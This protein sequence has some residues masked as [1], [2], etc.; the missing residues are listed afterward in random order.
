MPEDACL[1]TVKMYQQQLHLL[2]NWKTSSRDTLSEGSVCSLQSLCQSSNNSSPASLRSNPLS[3]AQSSRTTSDRKR[4][5]SASSKDSKSPCRGRGLGTSDKGV[6]SSPKLLGKSSKSPDKKQS[7]SAK[8]TLISNTKA[9]VLQASQKN[10]QNVMKKA[11]SPSRLGNSSN[12][13]S[14]IKAVDTKE[15]NTSPS[16]HSSKVPASKSE[17]LVNGSV[18]SK[19]SSFVASPP[20]KVQEPPKKSTKSLANPITNG[21][22]NSSSS[23][24]SATSAS[25]VSEVSGS[26]STPSSIITPVGAVTNSSLRGSATPVVHH[27]TG[28]TNKKISPYKVK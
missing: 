3:A 13:S 18:N 10:T 14:S 28:A 12:K 11:N 19:G 23:S 9:K 17:K 16:P 6:S 27:S 20:A 26:S 21:P 15:A 7:P 5:D 25:T 22:T 24:Q 8:G 1:D 2:L 4:T